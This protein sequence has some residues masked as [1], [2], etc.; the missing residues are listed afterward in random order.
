MNQD[1]LHRKLIAAARRNAPSERVP[2]SFEKRILAL[3]RACPMVDHWALW[4]Q[5]LW[6]AAASCVSIMLLLSAW[7]WFSPAGGAPAGTA[8]ASA[9]AASNLSQD[10]ENT[11]LAAAESEQS[12]DLSR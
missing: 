9:S 3:I 6:R 5:A 7:W 8:L 2:H 1:E 12:L 10:L 11:M 4:S